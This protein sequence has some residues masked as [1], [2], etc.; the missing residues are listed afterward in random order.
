MDNKRAIGR[1]YTRGNPFKLSPFINWVNKANI[2]ENTIIEPFAGAKDI[3]NLIDSAHLE[4]KRWELFDLHPGANGIQKR[5]TLT[6]F[7]KGF[8]V[9]ITNPPWLARNSATRRGLP[10]PK[11]THYDDM[12]KYALDLC[13]NNCNWVAAIIPE[14]FIRSNLF[15]DRLSD[16]ISLVPEK[17][18]TMSIE[19]KS[20]SVN[21]MF[22]DTEHPVGLALFN[23]NE[24]SDV[25]VW[26]NNQKLGTLAELRHYLPQ[27]SRNR[28]IRFNEPDGNLGLVAIDNTV[29][30][31]IRFCPPK[32]LGEY[33]VRYHGRSIT[34]IMVDGEVKICKLNSRLKL[35]REKTHDVFLTAFKGLRRDG[36]YRRRL[37]W[38]LARAIVDE[39]N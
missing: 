12:Y 25:I 19:R 7:P 18:Q 27:P 8:K 5:D 20:N 4:Y 24:T 36:F 17:E 21:S 16:F 15:L 6:D 30:P 22:E 26:R 10:Y 33:P 13:L 1:Y 39:D 14:A 31:S 2:Q 35:I 34:K 32:E 28:K 11:D 29:S 23:P 37:D 3:P 9:C 38:G